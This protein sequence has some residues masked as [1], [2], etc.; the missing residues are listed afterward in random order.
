[1]S[2]A[3]LSVV[4][5]TESSHLIDS[6]QKG[7]SWMDTAARVG[8]FAALAFITVISLGALLPLTYQPMV[9]LWN[10]KDSSDDK[11]IGATMVAS[12]RDTDMDDPFRMSEEIPVVEEIQHQPTTSVGHR[13]ANTQ[14]DFLET[15]DE[16]QNIAGKMGQQLGSE[17]LKELA[18]N[19]SKIYPYVNDS[20]IQGL[21]QAF[22]PDHQNTRMARS[23]KT[24][25]IERNNL[26]NFRK[27]L[28]EPV[29]HD[30]KNKL[31][32]INV[33]QLPKTLRPGVKELQEKLHNMNDQSYLELDIS[34]FKKVV[35]REIAC[36]DELI[37]ATVKPYKNV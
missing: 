37:Q 27:A 13:A 20:T 28:I 30:F 25:T 10:G 31:L 19:A 9:E 18:E 17:M 34:C 3:S 33:S 5:H 16:L 15:L 24:L 21:E 7:S 29:F 36:K 4:A 32:K 8:K 6:K 35:E 1:M 11:P 22:G 23:L 26:N 12:N 2:T 14:D